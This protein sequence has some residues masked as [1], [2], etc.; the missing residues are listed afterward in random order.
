M[1]VPAVMIRGR[2]W[3]VC[4]TVL[5]AYWRQAVELYCVLLAEH[6]VC[7]TVLCARQ[8]VELYCVLLAEHWRAVDSPTWLSVWVEPL[9]ESDAVPPPALA[10]I[11]GRIAQLAPGSAAYVTRRVSSRRRLPRHLWLVL[12]TAVQAAHRQGAP[13][14]NWRDALPVTRLREALQHRDDQVSH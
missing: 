1:A 13:G 10:Q 9:F 8:A 12:L 7:I 6:C 3:G 2:V 4:I 14:D 5:Y 11:T